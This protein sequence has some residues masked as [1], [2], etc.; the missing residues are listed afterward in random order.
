VEERERGRP[1]LQKFEGQLGVAMWGSSWLPF[2][3][4]RPSE[5]NTRIIS[6]TA[7]VVCVNK[8]K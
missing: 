1:G 5:V 3:R 7:S 6:L 4:P 2:V 8:L